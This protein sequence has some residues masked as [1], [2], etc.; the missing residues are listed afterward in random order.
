VVVLAWDNLLYT[1]R[2]TQTV[3]QNTRTP[4]ELIIVDNGSAPEAADYARRAADVAVMNSENLGFSVGMN[5]GLDAARGEWVVFCN[6]DTL[7]PEGW[8]TRLLETARAHPDA[9]IIVPALT[10]AKNPATVRTEPGDTV[11]VLPPFSAPP[12]AVI[13]LMRADLVRE[14]GAW[15]TEYEVASGEDVDLCFKVWVNELDIV[16]DSRVLVD[17]IGK[18][19]A[20]RL[21]DWQGLWARNRQQFLDKWQSDE[22]T[23]RIASCP[24]GRYQRNRAIARAVAGWMERYFSTRERADALAGGRAR[25]KEDLVSSGAD[26]IVIVSGEARRRVL[27][28]RRW[29]EA[30]LEGVDGAPS[31]VRDGAGKVYVVEGGRRRRVPGALL[32]PALERAFGAIR[33]VSD[34]EL[35]SWDEGV[36]VEV[37]EAPSAPPFVVIGGE[38]RSVKGLPLPHLIDDDVVLR[39]PKGGT[40]DLSRGR[41]LRRG[42]PA[43]ASTRLRRSLD[44]RGPVGT[45]KRGV[46]TVARRAKRTARRVVK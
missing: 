32:L 31:L 36:P 45:A 34:A 14:V 42:T 40:L 27:T 29:R 33:D 3:R 20:S 21:D 39:L 17:H 13:F 23:P 9:G 12:A 11:E 25:N 19:S 38:R 37:L 30:L 5:Q 6:N 24:P 22:A 2:F 44:R 10:E 1:Q 35:A 18:G 41:S 26:E 15:G 16:Y 8:D 46:R 7:L 28:A 4:Y 43:T